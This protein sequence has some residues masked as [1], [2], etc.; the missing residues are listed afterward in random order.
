MGAMK[1]CGKAGCPKLT[2]EAYCEE[3]DTR[4]AWGTSTRKKPLG[5]DKVRAKVMRRDKGVCVICGRKGGIVDH[6]IPMAWGGEAVWPG[7]LRVMCHPCHDS[8][9]RHESILGKR[10]WMMSD[11]EW[12]EEK[13]KFAAAWR[14]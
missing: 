5:W 1:V 10:R 6:F 3:H 12:V 7:N 13:A 2:N 9:T 14:A 8:K 4:V 11:D